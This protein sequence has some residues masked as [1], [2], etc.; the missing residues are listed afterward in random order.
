[1][2]DLME[3]EKTDY[4][5]LAEKYGNFQVP[6]ARVTIGT[7][8]YSTVTAKETKRRKMLLIYQL[9][10]R[11][12]HLEGTSVSILVGD[13]YDLEASKFKETAILGEKMVVEIGYGSIF[14]QIFTGYVGEIQFQY[15]G[16]KQ[17]VRITGF[18]AVAL[19]TQNSSARYYLKKKYSDVV[20]EIIGEYGTIL[21]IGTIDSSN[22][23]PQ[24]VLS[25]GN[26]NDYSYI[27]NVLCPLAGKEFYI[28]DGKAYFKTVKK[29]NQTPIIQLKLGRSL[30]DFRMTSSYA[31]IEISVCGFSEKFSDKKVLK[32][33]KDKTDSSQKS[34][35]SAVQKQYIPYMNAS[36][37]ESAE[38]YASYEIQQKISERQTAEGKCIGIPELIPGRCILIHGI[39]QSYNSKKFWIDHVN[40]KINENGFITEFFVK[41][42]S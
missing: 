28:F 37:E 27:K 6:A 12:Y 41:G 5:K 39:N 22:E 21:S 38:N 36:S 11:L 19:M 17:Y 16:T 3:S 10:A 34:A 30:L 29:R 33:K 1:M 40:H 31:N 35:V 26:L 15:M 23:K 20:N 42:W 4:T 14:Q 24:D 9:D 8:K 32:T 18:D 25:C 13:V 7:A 2:S